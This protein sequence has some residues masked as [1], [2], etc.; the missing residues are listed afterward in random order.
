[1]LLPQMDLAELERITSEGM[2]IRA[3]RRRASNRARCAA[4]RPSSRSRW[5]S[6]ASRT[7]AARAST[8]V[9]RDVTDQ[10]WIDSMLR[11]YNRALECA[12][13]GVVIIDVRTPG[14][15]VFYANPA[16]E[17]ITGYPPA[18]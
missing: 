7:S 15:P 14:H 13:S 16:F 2:L 17:R 12:T 3:S 9:V 4:T 8:C 6:R 10:R 11:L 1:M 18:R 5:R